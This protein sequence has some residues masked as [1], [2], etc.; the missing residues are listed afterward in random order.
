MFDVQNL[1]FNKESSESD[2]EQHFI[3]PFLNAE[4]PIGLGISSNYILTKHNIKKY[5]IDKGSAEK[6]YYP[7]YIIV[8]GGYPLVVIEAKKPNDTNM[9]ESY[10]E[11]R[12]YA[13]E[14]NDHFGLGIKPVKYI[15]STNGI[16]FFFGK[17]G[18]STPTF[19]CK[20]N[21]LVVGSSKL[22]DCLDFLSEKKLLQLV[23][24]LE[25]E[26]VPN[27]LNKP[28]RIIGG[29]SYQE[30]EIAKNPLGETVTEL[31]QWVFNPTNE[32][33]RKYIVN[34]GYIAVQG[35]E[36]I[37][38]EI[39]SVV[40]LATTAS[41]IISQKIKNTSKPTELFSVLSQN[42]YTQIIL[43][44]GKVGAGKTTFIDYLQ[45]RDGLLPKELRNKLLWARLDL[46]NAPLNKELIYS[47]I[48]MG[49]I[50][51]IQEMHSDVEYDSLEFLYKLY[52]PLINSFEKGPARLFVKGSPEYNSKLY[53]A[54]QDWQADLSLTLNC[55]IRH[56]A[57]ER[58]KT[59]IIVF[60]NCD[61]KDRDSQLLMFEVA[62]W[63]KDKLK[64]IIILPLRDETYDNYK[65]EKPLDTAIKQYSFRIHSPKFQ[66]VLTRRVEL[67]LQLISEKTNN[68]SSKQK[69]HVGQNMYLVFNGNDDG[70]KFL[71]SMLRAV[72]QNDNSIR[73]MMTGLSGGNIRLSLE[74]FLK[75]C[76]SGH[77]PVEE[78]IK[79]YSSPEASYTIPPYLA[80][81]AL[82]RGDRRFYFGRHSYIKNLLD[83]DITDAGAP[84]YLTRLVILRWLKMQVQ[85]D[86]KKNSALKGYNPI[87]NLIKEVVP[88]GFPIDLI[89]NQISYLAEAKCITTEDFQTNNIIAETNIKIAPAGYAH[90]DLLQNDITYLATIAED[91]RF[92]NLTLVNQ[93]KEAMIAS[94]DNFTLKAVIG[95]ADIV[96]NY[97]QT[98]ID[99]RIASNN[100]YYD[101]NLIKE[102]LS[103]EASKETVQRAKQKLSNESREN[104]VIE[105]FFE[106]NPLCSKIKGTIKNIA[107]FGIFVNIAENGKCL[108]TGLIHKTNLPSNYNQIYKEKQEINIIVTS[109][110]LKT[111]K[112]QL[113]LS[114]D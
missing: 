88:F 91:T 40:R 75:F 42:A 9:D 11:A 17:V 63:A 106:K 44:I 43:L 111:N 16:D 86:V 98:I 114:N 99:S 31:Y 100:S 49:I 78:I 35:N 55:Y 37:N 1:H 32:D 21:E 56:F 96:V 89:L 108:F 81:K 105:K 47:W 33:Q 27:Y 58:A 77:I 18:S 52:A 30:E 7:D 76:S 60:D 80:V 107:P 20:V 65:D 38:H 68:S 14:I 5:K 53:D 8:I 25:T 72:L 85:R 51:L 41:D 97:I 64:T 79:V 45:Y 22:N 6:V 59:L 26:H 95:M 83:A 13:N 61:K 2:V 104:G 103:I 70:S 67:A 34:N 10:R 82:M 90:L 12:L 36:R 113:E 48:Q 69:I 110:N 92:D 28:N 102:L 73:R 23:S 84:I 24:K 93:V 4:E 19:N 3:M 112:Y 62:S 94:Q 74:M 57:A 66:N 101:N 71:L 29:K 15:V 50:K 109:A 87:T 54:M 39:D 46:N